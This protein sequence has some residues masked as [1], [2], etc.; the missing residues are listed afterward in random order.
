MFKHVDAY[1]GDPIFSLMDTFMQ[2][3]RHNKVNLTIGFY[4]DDAGKVPNFHSINAA[5]DWLHNHPPA[6]PVYLPMEG[7]PDFRLAAQGLAFGEVLPT[8]SNRLATIQS[9]GGSG[10]LKVGADFLKRYF[11]DSQVWVSNPTWENHLSIFRGA[12]FTVNTYR[13]FDEQSKGLDFTGMLEDLALLPPQSVVLLHPCCHN[14][15]GV[16]LTASQWQQ[17]IELIQANS[18]IAFF[19]MAYQGFGTNLNSDAY[20]IRLMAEQKL[21]FLLS[22]SFSKIFSLYSERVGALTIASES[23]EIA[24]IVESQLKFTV[25]TNYSTP[26]AYGARLAEKVLG[27]ASLASQWHSELSDMRE[28]M[29]TMR[30][31][32]VSKLSAMRP[33]YDFRYLQSQQGMFSYTGLS[34]AQVTQLKEEFGIYMINSGRMCIAGLNSANIDAVA[35]ALAAVF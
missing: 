31:L 27:D 12:G 22:Q 9:L 17:V 19:D 18:L 21:P 5:K 33:D 15:T 6:S 13:Y 32:L 2:D 7:L 14:P 8:V 29:H 28:R 26:P 20:A 30:S 25:R 16:D 4:F 23:S 34:Q 11:P 35:K 10:A 3:Q 1:G 24:Q